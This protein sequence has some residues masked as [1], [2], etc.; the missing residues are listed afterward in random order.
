MGF[1]SYSDFLQQIRPPIDILLGLD[2]LLVK[3]LRS[4]LNHA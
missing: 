4:G 3:D 1:M 2:P